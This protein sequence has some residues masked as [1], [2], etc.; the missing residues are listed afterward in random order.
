MDPRVLTVYKSPYPKKRLGRPYDGGYV[1]ADIPDIN[2]ST[3]LGC[4]LG[5][6]ISFEE[7][8]V[9]YYPNVK[10]YLFDGTIDKLPTK[11]ENLFCFIKKNIDDYNDDSTT[12][13]LDIIDNND[14]IFLKMDIEGAEIPWIKSLSFEHMCRLK[15]IVL[16][17]HWPFNEKEID[18]FDKLNRTHYLI[19]FHGNNNVGVRYHRGVIIPDVFECTYLHKKYFSSN[20]ELNNENIPTSFDMPNLRDVRDIYIDYPPFVFK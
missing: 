1:I 5:D 11:N 3:L 18:V 17:F 16:E 14:D 9:N 13:M 8:F 10:S 4:G 6:D 7:D 20:P 2:Y 12:N 19:H 15:Q